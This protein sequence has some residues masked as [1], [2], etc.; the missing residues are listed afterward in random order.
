MASPP[1]QGRFISDKKRGD[2]A[3]DVTVRFFLYHFC[4]VSGFPGD[5]VDSQQPPLE[6][7]PRPALP[8]A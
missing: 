4:L 6:I 1:A 5:P 8:D 3:P 2:A 7:K